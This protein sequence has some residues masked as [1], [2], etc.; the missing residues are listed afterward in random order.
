MNNSY[1]TIALSFILSLCACGGDP[2]PTNPSSSSL[3]STS[4]S[5]TSSTSS[6]TQSS[7]A[8]SASSDPDVSQQSYTWRNVAIGGG[9][10]VSSVIADPND[11]NIFYARTDV[12]GAYRWEQSSESW[13]PLL[14]WVSTNERGLLGVDG[15]AVDPQVAGRVY[16]LA[17]TTYWNDGKSMFLRSDDYG[18]TWDKIEVTSQ[19][20]A[21]GNGMGRGNGER[22]AV[23]PNNSNI[24]FIGSRFDGLWKSTDR[25]SSWSKVT[26]FP[27]SGATENENGIPTIVFDPTS[28]SGGASQ[29]LYAGVSRANDNFYVSRDGGQSWNA[30]SGRPTAGAIMPQRIAINASGN[31]LYVTYGN[32]AGPHP[33]LW[34]GV[35][36][37]YNRG[38]L[39]K[40]EVSSGTWTDISPVDF[41]LEIDQTTNTDIHYGAYSGIAIDPNNE[42]RLLTTTINSYRGAQYWNDNG[43]YT[44]SWGDNIYFSDDGGATWRDMFRYYWQEGGFTP[45]YDMLSDNGIPWIRGSNIH[46][47]GAIVFD[48][49][50]AERA[51]VTSGNGVWSTNNL[52]DFYSE[53]EY[54][55]NVAVEKKYGQATWR[56]EARGI[57]ETVPEDVISI[58]GGPL[59]S[60]ILDYDG[61][62][63]EDVQV[64]SPYGRHSNDAGG[65]V[66]ALG[67]TTGLDYAAQA[68]VLVKAAKTR[69][70]STEYNE[71]PIGPV[72]WSSDQGRTWS[73]E[74]YTSN[75]P[76][77]LSG[78][79]VAI[80]TDGEVTLWMPDEASTMYRYLNSAWTEV[81][82]VPDTGFRPEADKVNAD[83]F[84]GYV[85]STGAF[86][87][88]DDKGTSF[89]QTA[90]LGT[91]SFKIA[92]AVPGF[93]G[94]VWVPLTNNGLARST[95]AGDSFSSINSVSYCEAVGFGKAAAGQSHPTVF[96]FGTV[97]GVTGVF[98]STDV[99][100]TWVRVNDDEHEYGGLANGEFV[101]GDMNIFG[102]VYMSTAGRGIVYG[103]P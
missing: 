11:R 50:N 19:F 61:F 59:V 26:T 99:G 86:Y 92:R 31:V 87:R 48:P 100:A 37:Y 23:D 98:R 88:S 90:S 83:L 56:F 16:I 39:F 22:I 41:M 58:E 1:K 76:A 102:R 28:A 27:L 78:G 84:Y 69:N 52:S 51:F 25:G 38:A 81:S 13:I 54:V 103:E 43:T 97:G 57:E 79:R 8:S 60:V 12:G 75:P 24:L 89:T 20:R 65:N 32:G 14:D 15:I 93:E 68:D 17:G 82:G 35:T 2:E 40:Y 80:S 21:H 63:H 71:I 42:N 44:D 64:H 53:T 73:T 4:T 67:S 3:S 70:V 33:Q 47:N 85:P 6:S 95:D 55:D 72:Q 30:V 74:T 91:G 66:V 96:I 36:D 7:S 45:D 34:N 9:G 29:T 5:S 94:H 49:Y 77:E 62:V 46:W 101:K 18:K 10:F